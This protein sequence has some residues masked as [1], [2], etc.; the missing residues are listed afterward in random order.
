GPPAAV[1]GTGVGAAAGTG[2]GA[3]AP[4]GPPAA[5]P[6]EAG[7]LRMKDLVARVATATGASAAAVRPAVDAT[8]AALGA[9]LAAGTA[10]NLPGFGRLRVVRS[11]EVAAGGEMLQLRLRRGGGGAG[12]KKG[13]AEDAAPAPGPLAE[14]GEDG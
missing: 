12:R 2:A 3:A 1:A 13:G 4:A 6:E 11:R 9:A 10:L 5:A 8:L 7:A 14:P